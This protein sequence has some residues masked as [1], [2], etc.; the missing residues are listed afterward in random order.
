MADAPPRTRTRRALLQTLRTNVTWETLPLYLAVVDVLA[1]PAW[2][3][4]LQ[5]SCDELVAA[6]MPDMA[7]LGDGTLLWLE[8]YFQ[9]QPSEKPCAAFYAHVAGSDTQRAWWSALRHAAQALQAGRTNAAVAAL[10][11]AQAQV[12]ASPRGRAHALALLQPIATP[13]ADALRR[14]LLS[15]P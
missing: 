15:Q 8:R 5:L 13:D 11:Q 14:A 7:T 1:A 6:G 12:A 3:P 2:R 10:A 9:A 4:D